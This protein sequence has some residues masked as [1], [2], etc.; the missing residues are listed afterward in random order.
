[1]DGWLLWWYDARRCS[2]QLMGMLAVTAALWCAAQLAQGI[3]WLGAALVPLAG[4]LCAAAI[5]AR[6]RLVELH[7]S[8][9]VSLVRTVGRRLVLVAAL[10]L[11]GNA[12]LSVRLN[13]WAAA[14]MLIATAAYVG[15]ATRS[16]SAASTAVLGVWL[17]HLLIVD[18]MLP[19]SLQL[20]PLLIAAG[21][22][23]L[24]TVLRLRDG[25]ALVHQEGE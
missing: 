9:P 8:L 23:V 11:A 22:L 6:E 2:R 7:L 5:V 1:M 3:S 25:D 21:G 12:L 19:G 16:V 24:L 13:G 18:R 15:A 4:A 10:L 20:V 14:V 17:G